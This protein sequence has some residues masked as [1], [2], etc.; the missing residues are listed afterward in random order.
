MTKRANI[1]IFFLKIGENNS[2]LFSKYYSLYHF[3]F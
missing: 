2:Y 3:I 1:F